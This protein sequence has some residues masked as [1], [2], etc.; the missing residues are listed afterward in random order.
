MG[1]RGW[2]HQRNVVAV[3][4]DR[5]QPSYP[6]ALGGDLAATAGAYGS[7]CWGLGVWELLP[8]AGCAPGGGSRAAG[9]SGVYALFRHVL[10]HHVNV[11]VEAWLWVRVSAWASLA[12]VCSSY[13]CKRPGGDADEDW[14]RSRPGGIPCRP[15]S[16]RAT[17]C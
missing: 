6:L 3:E 7:T 12:F 15:G 11:V 17:A 14:Y 2:A 5:V 10:E 1:A 13:S 4:E 9:G 8:V 16:E